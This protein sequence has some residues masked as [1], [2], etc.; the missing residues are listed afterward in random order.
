L[1]VSG[2]ARPRGTPEIFAPAATAVVASTATS[3]DE[4]RGLGRRH[5]ELREALTKPLVEFLDLAVRFGAC[6]APERVMFLPF[7]GYLLLEVRQEIGLPLINRCSSDLAVESNDLA[8]F[9]T[10]VPG[11]RCRGTVAAHVGAVTV[12]I[13]HGPSFA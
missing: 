9:R 1:G 10:L 3:E 7:S 12:Q 5:T 2:G 13:G 6:L 4:S 8:K 11:D